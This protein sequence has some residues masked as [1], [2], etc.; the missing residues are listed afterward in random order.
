MSTVGA[1]LLL[2]GLLLTV[3]PGPGLAVLFAAVAVLAVEYAWAR[4]L[5]DRLRAQTHR[6]RLPVRNKPAEPTTGTSS[7]DST[8]PEQPTDLGSPVG[9]DPL[10]GP[11]NGPDVARPTPLG[12]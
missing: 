9:P 4:H 6:F 1:F 5:L 8:D 12:T 11:D 10:A 2:L 7:A 3:L